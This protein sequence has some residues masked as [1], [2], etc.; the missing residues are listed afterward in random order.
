MK[1]YKNIDLWI[2]TSILSL[3][4]IAIEIIFRV[5]EK[6]TII[7]YATIRII[8]S[9]IILAFVFEFFIS[10]LPKKK[11]REIIHGV[12]I[13]IA[14]IYAYIQ[15]GFHNYLGMY[16]SAGTTSQAGAVMNYLKDF[17]A[18]FHIIQYLIWVPFIIY[19]AYFFFYKKWTQEERIIEKPHRVFSLFA[20]LFCI[21]LYSLTIM[22]DFMQN[23]LQLIPNSKL[24]LSPTNS[25]IAVN[26]FGITLYG[27]LD[28]KQSIF[29]VYLTSS[30]E[31]PKNPQEDLSRQIDDTVWKALIED[32][33]NKNYNSLNKY[34]ISQDISDKNEYTGYFKDKN[35][36]VVM[37]ESANEIIFKEEYYPNLAKMLKNSW[38]WKNNYSPRNTCST[39]DNE[40]IGMT[41]L[42]P[43]NTSCTVCTYPKNSYF[44]SI[45]NQFSKNGYLTSSFHDLDSYY[46]PRHIYHEAMGSGKYYDGHELGM[47]FDSNDHIEW[48]SDEEFIELVSEK[49]PTDERFMFWLTTVSPHTPYHEDSTLSDL[50][51][52]LFEDTDYSPELKRYLAKLKVT[53]DALGKLIE[54]LEEKK[55]LDDTVIVLYGDH[56]PYGLVDKDVQS[57][58]EYDISDFYEI[59]RTPFL[60]YNSKLESKVFEEKTFYLNILPT[61][62]NLFDLDYDPRFYMGEDLFA[63]N[64]SGRVVFAD[65]SWEDAKAR[66][67]ASNSTISYF[68]ENVTYTTEEIKKINQTIYQKKEMSKLA[69]SSNY[70]DY[71]EKAL[72]EKQEELETEKEKNDEKTNDSGITS[73][74]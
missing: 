6:I 59:E 66:Y 36:I 47:E 14:S 32:E 69:I 64:Y 15:I 68:D 9:S 73:Q 23:P 67:D 50:Y 3:F 4:L 39:A 27:L 30:V 7:D 33:K 52:D 28:V 5:L 45:F 37:L 22:L 61:I 70:F 41:S 71:L 54:L 56:Y 21:I 29:P 43:L 72:S 11:T 44:Q 2:E 55:I 19:L 65:G 12:I 48:P 40:F 26:Q 51:Y 31:T 62:A 74:E 25:S 34:F 13:F 46:Y 58:L 20:T 24:I 10:F 57:V 38:H 18:S 8:L 60:I 63:K 17:L 49:I 1:K 53:D 16:I 42:Y 35:L